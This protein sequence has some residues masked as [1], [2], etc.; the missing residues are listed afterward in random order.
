[1]GVIH[2]PEGF[3]ATAQGKEAKRQ[4]SL[5]EHRA[6]LKAELFSN[7]RFHALKKGIG[8]TQAVNRWDWREPPFPTL[9]LSSHFTRPFHCQS[10]FESGRVL[11]R[12]RFPLPPPFPDFLG[13]QRSCWS[14]LIQCSVTS[15]W[16]E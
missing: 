4:I 16:P 3:G 2:N 5:A 12:E 7:L 14:P 10:S 13:Q 9:Y 6:V 1:M 8:F 15:P 11:F